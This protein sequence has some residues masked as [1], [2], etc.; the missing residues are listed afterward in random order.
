MYGIGPPMCVASHAHPAGNTARPARALSRSR[1]CRRVIGQRVRPKVTFVVCRRAKCQPGQRDSRHR[2]AGAGRPG[3]QPDVT[4]ARRDKGK[5]RT[6][7]GPSEAVSPGPAESSR[8]RPGGGTIRPPS[9]ADRIVP[10]L[11][12]RRSRTGSLSSLGRAG[13]SLPPVMRSSSCRASVIETLSMRSSARACR[14]AASLAA[15]F[16]AV[17]VRLTPPAPESDEVS[18]RPTWAS[19]QS[20]RGPQSQSDHCLGSGA[21]STSV[22]SASSRRSQVPSTCR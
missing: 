22:C 20:Q 19:I 7:P 16:S 17:A 10:P 6:R 15:G 8:G 11:T 1:S 18:G 4:A 2:G 3:Q 9:A 13:I 21:G 12:V 14:G 5:G